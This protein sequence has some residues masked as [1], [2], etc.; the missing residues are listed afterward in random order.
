M[1]TVGDTVGTPVYAKEENKLSILQ[2]GFENQMQYLRMMSDV[3][4]RLFT[5]YI[6]VQLVLANWLAHQQR[7]PLTVNVGIMLVDLV[8]AGLAIKAFWVNQKR[9]DFAVKVV[10]NLSSAL[11]FTVTGAFLRERAIQQNVPTRPWFAYYCGSVLAA[12]MGVGLVL[13]GSYLSP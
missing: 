13:F 12:V 2:L 1:C 9:R 7:Q 6:T 3:D 8:F 10:T 4:L 5:G 11:G